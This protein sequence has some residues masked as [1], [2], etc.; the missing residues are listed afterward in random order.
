MSKKIFIILFLLL[1]LFFNSLILSRSVLNKEIDDVH[2]LIMSSKEPKLL[3]SE[4]L[5]VIPFYMGK[6]ICE[7]PDWIKNIKNS[8]KKI[9]LHGVYHTHK[10]FSVDRSDEYIDLGIQEFKKAF[11]YYPTV[12]KPPS[13]CISKNNRKKFEERGIEIKTKLNQLFREVY[14]TNGHRAK[15]GKL[16]GE[17]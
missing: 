9:G 15:N 17:I 5:W 16:I 7:F 4:W 12:F 6:S 2:P 3:N 11:G 10:E 8:G 13:M 1:I 14:H